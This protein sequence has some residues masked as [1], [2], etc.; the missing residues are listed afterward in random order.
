MIPPMG[1][2][3]NTITIK[4]R[5]DAITFDGISS[6]LIE[7]GEISYSITRISDLSNTENIKI[8]TSNTVDIST[9]KAGIYVLNLYKGN[10][11]IQSYKFAK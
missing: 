11:R 4:K 5:G 9:E 10:E 7:K 2:L 1:S 3:A 6:R 8:A